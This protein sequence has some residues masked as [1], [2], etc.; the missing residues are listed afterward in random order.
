MTSTSRHTLHLENA[1]I[2]AHTGYPDQQYIM[3]LRAPLTAAAAL[4]GHFV[5]LQCDTQL[6][7]RRPM[8][9]MRTDG[10]QGWVEILY[11]VSGAG[12]QCL[13]RRTVGE[14]VSL[15]G[16]IGVPFKLTCYR[17]YP[18]L[19]GGGVGIPPMIFFSGAY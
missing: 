12:S 16:P 8:S 5:H 11:K 19:V 6:P 13:M 1:E 14:T 4:P 3:R 18:L 2:I 10:Q 9:I 15:I 7:L 17:R